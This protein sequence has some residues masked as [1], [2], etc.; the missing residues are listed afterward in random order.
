MQGEFAD[1]LTTFK[2]SRRLSHKKELYEID[3]S[4]YVKKAKVI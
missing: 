2:E 4:E 1:Y 3:W